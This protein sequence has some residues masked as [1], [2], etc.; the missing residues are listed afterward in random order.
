MQVVWDLLGF[1]GKALIVFV[2]FAASVGFFF[3]RLRARREMEPTVTLR[4]VSERW[5]RNVESIKAAL[6][7]AKERK[8]AGRERKRATALAAASPR[9]KKVYVID[10]KGD[11]LA[12]GNDTLREEVTVVAGIA[13]EGDEVV[14]RLESSGGAV[15]GYGLAAAQLARIRDR[16]IPL[17]VCVDKVAASGGYMMACVADRIVAAPFA[18]LGSIG[19]VASVPNL[20]RVLDRFGVDYEEVTAGKFKRTTSLFGSVTE[21]G[22]MKLREEIDETHDL[23]KRFVHGMRP[24]LDIEA[25]STGE[26]W[27]GTRAMEL[28]LIDQLG[29]SDDYLVGIAAEARVFE[30][31]CDKPRT[32]R[33][34][35]FSLAKKAAAILA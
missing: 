4:E 3:A 1:S 35:A 17:T 15:H 22:K 25:V 5:R 24:K 6:V 7:P 19:V 33:E 32:V 18:I 20:H 26:H 11:L 34:R 30:V 27:Y 31:L 13:Q 21:E 28:G 12:T 29:T 10:F 16:K 2:T 14:V 9:S 8:R 23:F